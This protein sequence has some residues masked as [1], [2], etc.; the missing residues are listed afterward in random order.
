MSGH[1]HWRGE[2]RS[3]PGLS[4]FVIVPGKNQ[5]RARAPSRRGLVLFAAVLS[6][7]L[8]T[9]M[10]IAASSVEAMAEAAAFNDKSDSWVGLAAIG[11]VLICAFLGMVIV[12]RYTSPGPR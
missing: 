9:V 2:T 10:T 8:G 5:R 6:L 1:P 3:D 12:H 7:A 4:G 11:S